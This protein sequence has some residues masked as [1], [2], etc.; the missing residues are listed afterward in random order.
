MLLSFRCFVLIVVDRRCLSRSSW[1]VMLHDVNCGTGC[2]VLSLLALPLRMFL[3]LCVYLNVETF[4]ARYIL[5]V[6]EASSQVAVL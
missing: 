3:F 1:V 6:V 5:H 4:V 2:T